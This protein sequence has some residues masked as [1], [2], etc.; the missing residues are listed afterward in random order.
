M[1]YG[2]LGFW[3]SSFLG[4]LCLFR[5]VCLVLGFGLPGFVILLLHDR[6]V[7]SSC[8]SGFVPLWVCV[9]L[10]SWFFGLALL[11]VLGP[12]CNGFMAL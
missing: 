1:R 2:V 5:G 12:W 3:R 8:C 10:R 11:W 9:V 4:L 7:L 6:P